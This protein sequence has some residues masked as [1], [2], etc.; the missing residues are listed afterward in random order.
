M[1]RIV[2]T[3]YRYKR[4]P[5]KKKPRAVEIAATVVVRPAAGNAGREG[6]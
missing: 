4:P 6:R 3:S 1:T 5:P 2:V